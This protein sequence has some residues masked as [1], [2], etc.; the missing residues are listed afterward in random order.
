MLGQGEFRSSNS[1]EACQE[2]SPIPYFQFLCVLKEHSRTSEEE[3]PRPGRE[4]Q[5]MLPTAG[6]RLWW[7]RRRRRRWTGCWGACRR[8]TR[9]SSARRLSRSSQSQPGTVPPAA[10]SLSAAS[11]SARCA[12]LPAHASHSKTQCL[13]LECSQTLKF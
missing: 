9:C 2:S 5:M 4:Q 10:S 12:H 13:F 11:R 7:M 8:R 1:R 3:A 6:T